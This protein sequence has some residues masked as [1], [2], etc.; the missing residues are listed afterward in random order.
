M[1]KNSWGSRLLNIFKR[2]Q[3]LED[4]TVEAVQEEVREEVNTQQEES[5]VTINK[6]IVR[7]VVDIEAEDKKAAAKKRRRRLKNGGYR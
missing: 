3:V 6:S 1:K 2:K 5:S 4:N 7:E